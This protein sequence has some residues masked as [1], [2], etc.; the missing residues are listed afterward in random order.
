MEI[1]S[2]VYTVSEEES[3]SWTVASYTIL[4]IKVKNSW[5]QY[6]Y[7]EHLK[8]VIRHSDSITSEY[9]DQVDE[10]HEARAR[11]VARSSTLEAEEARSGSGF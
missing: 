3:F 4:V 9:S 7:A 8:S 5:Q 2:T 11:G 6:K 1:I 10:H